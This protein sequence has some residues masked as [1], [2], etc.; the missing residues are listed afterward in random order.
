[1]V[2]PEVV[3]VQTIQQRSQQSSHVQNAEIRHHFVLHVHDLSICLRSP[4]THPPH[5]LLAERSTEAPE[6]WSEKSP[7]PLASEFQPLLATWMNRSLC[8]PN[9]CFRLQPCEARDMD[10]LWTVEAARMEFRFHNG[11]R[12]TF[13]RP[14]YGRR[15]IHEKPRYHESVSW[16]Q[17]QAPG[18]KRPSPTRSSPRFWRLN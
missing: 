11:F 10:F 18:P 8:G 7:R 5:R 16:L 14:P 9:C 13:D 12:R 3:K 6:L 1:M 15:S 2:N 17:T 4:S